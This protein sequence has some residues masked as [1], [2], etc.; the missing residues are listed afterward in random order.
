MPTKKPTLVSRLRA[1]RGSLSGTLRHQQERAGQLKRQ[2][3]E[4]SQLLEDVADGRE[5]GK[6]WEVYSLT[7]AQKQK[8]KS[9]T[10]TQARS[11]AIKATATCR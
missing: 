3:K 2:I 1:A 5:A 9:L 10:K 7:L 4:T 11:A 8:L 6:V